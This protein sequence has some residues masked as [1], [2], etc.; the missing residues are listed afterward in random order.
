MLLHAGA[1]ARR[2]LQLSSAA[3]TAPTQHGFSRIYEQ[4]R[5]IARQKLAELPAGQT[6]QA[7][8][9]V[10]EAWLRLAGSE[11]EVP[12]GD[13]PPLWRDAEHLRAA[14]AQA[15]RW[16][17]VDHQRRRFAKKRASQR[18]DLEPDELAAREDLG[19]D[20]DQQSWLRLD[21]ALAELEQQDPRRSRIVLL[22]YFAGM[23]V[24]D[25]AKAMDLSPATV[26]RDWQFARAWLVRAMGEPDG[27]NRG[28]REES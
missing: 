18:A 28:D 9:L 20:S 11:S 4:L 19:A 16:I 23:S 6:L 15:M 12:A 14:T 2:Q 24:E 8:A 21:A 27:S 13:D 17:L 3:V 10:H 5:R 1:S 26:K 25:T 7:T 22:R